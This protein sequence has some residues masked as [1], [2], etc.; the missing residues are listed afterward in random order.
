[1]ERAGPH[2][3]RP[4]RPRGLILSDTGNYC[5]VCSRERGVPTCQLGGRCGRWA[6]NGALSSRSEGGGRET[7]S[8]AA[9]VIR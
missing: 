2:H 1:M 4:G 9:A 8:E 6:E 7:R 3:V 5:R